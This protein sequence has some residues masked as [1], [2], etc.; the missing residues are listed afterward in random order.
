MQTARLAV[1]APE[2]VDFSG[3]RHAMDQP[4]KQ[5]SSGMRA[6]LGFALAAASE[7]ALYLIDEVLAVGDL[8]FRRRAVERIRE[9]VSGGAS[10]VFVSHDLQ[11]VREVCD[12]AAWL[13]DG[14][15]VHEGPVDEVIEAY[16]GAGWSS[17]V[18]LGSGPVRLFDLA[19]NQPR[20]AKGASALITAVVEVKT[21]APDRRIE[22]SLRDPAGRGLVPAPSD[23]QLKLL[24]MGSADIVEE[25]RLATPGSFNLEA[26]TGPIDGHGECDLVLSVVKGREGTVEAEAWTTLYFGYGPRFSSETMATFDFEVDCRVVRIE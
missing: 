8:Q 17:G 10:V 1:L 2:V 24:T 4:V 18:D 26:S 25:G 20:I 22:L 13:E 16:G 15:I 11:L 5:W 23:H 12:R 3:V 7:G 6:R 21:A 19:L 14:K 9:L